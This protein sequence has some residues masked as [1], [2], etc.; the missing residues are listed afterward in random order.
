MTSRHLSSVPTIPAVPAAL[1][2]TIPEVMTLL[3]LSKTQIFEEIRR[4]RIQSVK[5]GRARRVP[6]Q[7]LTAFVA[8]LIEE[9][10]EVA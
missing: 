6:A 10:Q 1:L 3:R 9:A 2:H 5:V 4:G 7:S 8:L